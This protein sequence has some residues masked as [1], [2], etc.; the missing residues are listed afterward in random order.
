MKRKLLKRLFPCGV[1]AVGF[2]ALG[3]VSRLWLQ[4]FYL[5]E[6]TARHSYLFLWAG[7]LVL[8]SL[9]YGIL[10]YSIT[11]GNAAGVVIGQFLGDLLAARGERKVLPDMKPDMVE[12][13]TSHRGVLIWLVTVAAFFVGGMVI[14]RKRRAGE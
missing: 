6:W 2:G 11:A 13:L 7:A 5:F 9:G 4:E 1:A 10:S 8:G 3:L 12:R 14:Y